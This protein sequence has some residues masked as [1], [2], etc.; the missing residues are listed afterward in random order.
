M[1][2]GA[3]T[4]PTITRDGDYFGRTVALAA[5][6]AARGGAGEVLV[7][8]DL[9][10]ALPDRGEDL[11]LAWEEHGWAELKGLTGQHLLWRVA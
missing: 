4:G 3:H 7:T 2:I 8:D 11:P 5:R 6:V 9:R 1:R 10:A